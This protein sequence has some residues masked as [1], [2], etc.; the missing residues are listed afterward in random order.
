[1]ATWYEAR[2]TGRRLSSFWC[3]LLAASSLV[4]VAATSA[5][6]AEK[7]DNGL[8]TQAALNGPQC[9]KERGRIQ[10]V[11]QGWV[12]CVKPWPANSDNGGATSPGVTKSAI[13]VVVLKAPDQTTNESRS[14]I[15]DRAT[16]QFATV[17]D[18]VRDTLPI[19]EKTYQ[20]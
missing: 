18:A 16:G 13:K 14:P 20:Q 17:E 6:A 9:D 10:F 15:R 8:G 1:M 5:A 7:L 2:C 19:F 11:Y 3:A 12:P 4:A